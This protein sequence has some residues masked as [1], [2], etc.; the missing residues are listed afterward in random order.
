MY[1]D[2]F[3]KILNTSSDFDD[4]HEQFSHI[5]E[6][7]IKGDYFEWFSQLFF[8]FDNRWKNTVKKCWL[9][10]ELPEKIR[11]KLKL[12][13]N[14]IGIDLII[15]TNDNYYLYKRK[16]INKMHKYQ[17]LRILPACRKR[18][19]RFSHRGKQANCFHH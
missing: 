11:I 13:E 10:N 8:M 16:R 18:T 1:D 17:A 2:K 14:D 5:K 19:M 12:P 9:L 4:I 3:K 15:K 7:K 6:N